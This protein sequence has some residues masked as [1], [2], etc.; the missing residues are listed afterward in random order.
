M[1]QNLG[2]LVKSADIDINGSAC[3]LN[4]VFKVRY[5]PYNLYC[6]VKTNKRGD[7]TL[8]FSPF[9]VASTAKSATNCVLLVSESERITGII[10]D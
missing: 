3:K 8:L 1:A 4:V 5:P 2:Y 9:T 10:W 6:A 7:L